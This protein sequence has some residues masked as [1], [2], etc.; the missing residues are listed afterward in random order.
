VDNEGLFPGCNFSPLAEKK[1]EKVKP[2]LRTIDRKQMVLLPVEIERL[3]PFDHE[4]RA[5]WEFLGSLDLTSYHDHIESKEGK[6]GAPAFD[7][8]LMI[9][10]WLYSYSKGINSAREVASSRN[11][12]PPISG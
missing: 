12:I 3:I 1:K 5:L 2:R 4:V 6:A 11:T 8:R 9:S 10:I 7:P